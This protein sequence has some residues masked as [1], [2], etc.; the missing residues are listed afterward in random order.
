[1]KSIHRSDVPMIDIIHGV[2]V[3]NCDHEVGHSTHSS[4]HAYLCLSLCSLYA[5]I[6]FDALSSEFDMVQGEARQ[7][8]DKNMELVTENGGLKKKLASHIMEISD[9]TRERYV[10]THRSSCVGVC[11]R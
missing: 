10:H 4:S 5:Y 9:L 1:M 11:Y 6:D 8:K 3:L 7:F 2:G